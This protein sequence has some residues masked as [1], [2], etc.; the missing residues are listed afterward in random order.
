VEVEV[1]LT[2][3]E[4]QHRDLGALVVVGMLPL[5][6]LLLA[7]PALPILGAVVVVATTTHPALL[8]MGAL[9]VL[10]SLF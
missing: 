3:L 9:V 4:L 6:V 7:H 2:A 5:M 1:Q 10:E 8:K